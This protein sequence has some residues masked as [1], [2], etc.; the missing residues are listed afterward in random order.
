MSTGGGSFTFTGGNLTAVSETFSVFRAG[1]PSGV[2]PVY[3]RA[4]Q[5]TYTYDVS[6]INP[7][8]GNF[9][10]PA[11]GVFLPAGSTSLFGPFYTLYGGIDNPFNLSPRNVETALI[12]SGTGTTDTRYSYS[13]NAVGLP[14]SRTTNVVNGTQQLTTEVL[15]YTYE[16][17]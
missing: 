9:I 8:Y 6:G 3:S 10:I 12:V 7:F 5:V 2:P 13:Y 17:Y 4:L 15:R 16:S 14:T 1:E 11:P